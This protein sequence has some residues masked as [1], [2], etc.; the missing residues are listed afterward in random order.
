[1]KLVIEGVPNTVK[2]EELVTVTPLNDTVIGPEPAPE[3]TEVVMLV[4]VYDETTAG[5]PLNSTA[6][7]AIKFVPVMV[8]VVPTPAAVGLK[9]VIVGDGNMLKLP[10]LKIVTPLTVMEI[11][12]EVAP[13]GTAVVILEEVD[14][15]TTAIV[16]LNLTTLLEGVGLKFVPE[17]TTTAPT[18]PLVGLKPVM[19]GVG[20]TVK[21]DAL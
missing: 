5:V 18:A 1:M 15:V 11:L 16:L 12:P 8:T 20:N 17:I 14:A 7:G 10:V 19:V 21:V 13:A 9:L 6:G 3:G 2:F 4:E